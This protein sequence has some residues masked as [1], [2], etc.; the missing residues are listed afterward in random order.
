MEISADSQLY[1]DRSRAIVTIKFRIGDAGSEL[2]QVIERR[3]SRFMEPCAGVA[4]D[5]GNTSPITSCSVLTPRFVLC[6]PLN[7]ASSK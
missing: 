2:D 7:A 3:V 4:S 6:N 1:L 5:C